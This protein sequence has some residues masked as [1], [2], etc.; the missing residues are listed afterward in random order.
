MCPIFSLLVV[1][2]PLSVDIPLLLLAAE[3]RRA[4]SLEAVA[5]DRQ[6]VLDG[7]LEVHDLPHVG[8]RDSAVLQLQVLEVCFRLIRP[9]HRP[10]ELV[11]V[12]LDRQGARP[13]LAADF[14]LALPCPDWVYV[15]RAREAADSEYQRHHEDRLHVCL[16]EIGKGC[17]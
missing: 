3:F 17:G 14:V 16:R 11:P 5:V 9:A 7:D 13:L 6:G 15:G 1:L 10:G 4:F 2:L 8:K 12:F